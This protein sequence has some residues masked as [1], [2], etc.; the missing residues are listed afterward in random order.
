MCLCVAKLGPLLTGRDLSW[1]PAEDWRAFHSLPA[2]P[3]CCWLCARRFKRSYGLAAH[4]GC[5]Q[6]DYV[7]PTPA[8]Q[9][10]PPPPPPPPQG[11]PSRR[12][13]F[14]Y[15]RPKFFCERENCGRM[16]GTIEGL[17]EHHRTPHIRCPDCSHKFNTT[18]QM[19][20][21]ERDQ[22]GSALYEQRLAAFREAQAKAKARPSDEANPVEDAFQLSLVA[23]P[24]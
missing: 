9:P 19:R 17:T 8:K 6:P 24:S 5:H 10:P 14:S 11:R 4:L 2:T 1:L 13:L 21:H 15:N 18:G 16:F 7:P 12:K 23:A 20:R 3:F 22:H